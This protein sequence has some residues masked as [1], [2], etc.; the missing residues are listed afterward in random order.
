MGKKYKWV[1]ISI[2]LF[3]CYIW[4][5]YFYRASSVDAESIHLLILSILLTASA[6]SFFITVKN[7]IV[8]WLVFIF[9]VGS[10]FYIG[11]DY[12]GDIRLIQLIV[13]GVLVSVNLAYYIARKRSQNESKQ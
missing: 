2:L 7:G 12:P 9:I 10:T 11:A 5:G 13:L 4:G 3:L 1:V 6:L 8:R